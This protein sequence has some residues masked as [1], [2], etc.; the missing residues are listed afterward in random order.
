[1]TSVA[2][3]HTVPLAGRR[4]SRR[5]VPLLTE[6]GCAGV[7]TELLDVIEYRTSHHGGLDHPPDSHVVWIGSGADRL[8]HSVTL[9]EVG[10]SVDAGHGIYTSLCGARFVPLPMLTGPRPRCARCRRQREQWTATS[11]PKRLLRRLTSRA[12]RT[13]S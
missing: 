10:A 7:R 4:G 3:H 6:A 11:T 8:D 5:M 13:E 1:M 9:D 2:R 12:R